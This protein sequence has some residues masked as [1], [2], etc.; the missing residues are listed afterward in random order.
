MT[1]P[2]CQ[3]PRMRGANR[4][5]CNYVFE[6]DAPARGPASGGRASAGL[7]P[8][9][10]G[11]A[12]AA[13]A[14]ALVLIGDQAETEGRGPLGL[15]LVVT[16]VFSVAGAVFDWSWFMSARRAQLIVTVLTRTGARVFYALAGGAL[17]GV[18]VGLVI[19]G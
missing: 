2:L 1:C 5:V 4:C 13:G 14:L 12:V 18:G 11:V 16:G 7:V 9:L 3:V 15:F 10:I 17:A 8:M 19:A 6:Y